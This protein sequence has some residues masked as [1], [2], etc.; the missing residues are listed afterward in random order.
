MMDHNRQAFEQFTFS[1]PFYAHRGQR[2]VD[3]CLHGAWMA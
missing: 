2:Y 3:G 1:Q